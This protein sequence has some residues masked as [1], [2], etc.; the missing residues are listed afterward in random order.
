MC[1]RK[2]SCLVLIA[3]SSLNSFSQL[4]G[5]LGGIR[6]TRS[7]NLEA[8]RR[9]ADD[10]QFDSYLAPAVFL[11][12]GLVSLDNKFVKKF[13]KNVQAE[14]SEDYPTFS[15]NFDDYLQ[16]MPIATTYGLSAVGVKGKNNFVDRTAMLVISNVLMRNSVSF[17]KRK[18][19]RLRPNSSDNRS[20]PSG[21]TAQ[22]FL[23]AEFLAQE[24]GDVS[25]W[26]SVAGYTMASATGTFRLF[27]N[28]HW[29]SDVVA[30]AGIGILS[31]KLS[32]AV[33]PYLKEKVW[34][35][36][37]PEFIFMPTYQEGAAGFTFV[38]SFK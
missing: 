30:G 22:A 1:C 33:Y 2:V 18:T 12:Y 3:L 35:D 25:V 14:I 11:G 5:S 37:S 31:V 34:K 7:I 26:Y 19:H 32:Y 8:L 16:Y 36:K 20:F 38:K 28:R 13:D 21:H 29:F 9:Q 10:N 24:Y 6:E 4:S 17:L 15:N 27:N 23:G